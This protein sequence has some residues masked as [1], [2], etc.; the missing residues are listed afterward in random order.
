MK[1]IIELD[2]EL[3]IGKHI[4]VNGE[5][6]VVDKIEWDSSK[7]KYLVIRPFVGSMCEKFEFEAQYELSLGESDADN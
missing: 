4:D 1:A 2:E 7:N 3:R 6:F 5:D